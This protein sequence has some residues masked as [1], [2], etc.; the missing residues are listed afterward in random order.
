M[1]KDTVESKDRSIRLTPLAAQVLEEMYQMSPQKSRSQIICE[2]LILMRGILR[3][4]HHESMG[5]DVAPG[6]ILRQP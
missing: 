2:A 6:D 3:K 1:S 5:Q 4:E